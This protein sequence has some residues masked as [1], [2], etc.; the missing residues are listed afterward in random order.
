MIIEEAGDTPEERQQYNLRLMQAWDA[1]GPAPAL[2]CEDCGDD[3]AQE[4]EVYGDVLCVDCFE[5]NHSRRNYPR[6][7]Y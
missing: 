6:E 3:D 5:K 1:K 4:D 2:V 7:F